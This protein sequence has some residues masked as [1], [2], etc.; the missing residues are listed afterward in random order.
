MR[1]VILGTG[2]TIASR[3]SRQHGAVIAG[4]SGEELMRRLGD[5][6]ALE[7]RVDLVK[8]SL[9]ADGRFSDFA[10]ETG[11]RGLVL[12]AFGRGDATRE[13]TAAVGRA[14]AAGLAVAVTSRSPHGRIAPIYTGGGGEHDLMQAGAVFAGDLCGA[15]AR[16]LPSVLLDAGRSLD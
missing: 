10:R 1:I 4:M 13:I 14:A 6:T 8:A 12:E 15:N 2:G 5:T 16:V 11:S 3:F 9:G 7:A